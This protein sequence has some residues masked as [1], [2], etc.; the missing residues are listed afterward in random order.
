MMIF[1]GENRMSLQH[2]GRARPASKPFCVL[3]LGTGLPSLTFHGACAPL[4][5]NEISWFF[6]ARRQAEAR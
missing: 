5:P 3:A 4:G 6:P 1:P 2:A